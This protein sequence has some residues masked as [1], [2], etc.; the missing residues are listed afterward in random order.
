MDDHE[1]SQIPKVNHH[2]NPTALASLMNSTLRPSCT[3]P[4]CWQADN[5][6]SFHSHSISNVHLYY[7]ILKKKKKTNCIYV[8]L[9][10]CIYECVCIYQGT[11]EGQRGSWIP[12]SWSYRCLWDAYLVT[13]E[14][15]SELQF[16]GFCFKP[17]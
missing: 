6:I 10:K 14:L 12:Q 16:S 15:R 3:V 11:N 2:Y 5:V 17:S 9:N 7:H 13:Q 1:S 4:W 8:C